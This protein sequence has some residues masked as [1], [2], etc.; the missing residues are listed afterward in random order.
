MFFLCQAVA[1]QCKVLIRFLLSAESDRHPNH[2]R[3]SRADPILVL[4]SLTPCTLECGGKNAAYVDSSVDSI[5]VVARRIVWARTVNCGMIEFELSASKPPEQ[6]RI[7]AF[8]LVCVTVAF[9]EIRSGIFARD[10]QDA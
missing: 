4:N 5:D 9:V 2:A 7:A 1:A 3:I 8:G 10:Q 6:S